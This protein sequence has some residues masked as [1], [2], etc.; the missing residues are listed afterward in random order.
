MKKVLTFSP[1]GSMLNKTHIFL[2]Q[3][4]NDVYCNIKGKYIDIET[5]IRSLK[6]KATIK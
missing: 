2:K 5:L 3:K 1:S 4:T 6:S